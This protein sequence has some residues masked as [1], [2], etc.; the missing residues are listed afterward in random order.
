VTPPYQIEALPAV[1]KDLDRLNP[2]IEQRIAV[3]ISALAANPRPAGAHPIAGKP[4]YYRI[5]VGDYRVVYGVDDRRALVTIV[6]VG[7]RRD[8]YERMLRRI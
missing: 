5:R 1:E 8:V 2:H 6:I 7:R 4:G 3:R